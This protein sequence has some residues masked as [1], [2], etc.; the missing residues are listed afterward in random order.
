[1]ARGKAA[2]E[3]AVDGPEIGAEI[4]RPASRGA[5]E[6][7]AASTQGCEGPSSAAQGAARVRS[8][9]MRT[10]GDSRF[11]DQVCYP[12]TCFRVDRCEH[13]AWR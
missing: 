8:G 11:P 1:M 10:V 9:C 13:A 2:R 5:R 6:D 12:P 7:Q 3:T 4:K